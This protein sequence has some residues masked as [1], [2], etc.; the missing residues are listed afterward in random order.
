MSFVALV[1]INVFVMTNL[2]T[3]LDKFSNNLQDIDLGQSLINPYSNQLRVDIIAKLLIE[4]TL[5]LFISN[6]GIDKNK[7]FLYFNEKGYNMTSSVFRYL[8]NKN[9]E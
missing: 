7:D 5:K 2:T 3:K 9:L 8:K 1:S 4:G 6:T